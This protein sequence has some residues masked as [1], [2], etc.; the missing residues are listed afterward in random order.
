MGTAGTELDAEQRMAAEQLAIAFREAMAG[1]S[2]TEL[3][4][5][6]NVSRNTIYRILDANGLPSTETLL[7]LARELRVKPGALLDGRV[8]PLDGEVRRHLTTADEIRQ[9]KLDV[10]R[11]S[12]GLAEVNQRAA[13]A[14][15]AQ[16]SEKTHPRRAGKR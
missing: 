13:R 3:Y 5:A 16:P 6:T 10:L 8:V 1:R 4:E 11:L 12:R 7:T 14:Q 2:P 15:G 9:L